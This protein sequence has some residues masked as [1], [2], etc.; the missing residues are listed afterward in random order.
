MKQCCGTHSDVRLHI[1]ISGNTA[2][3]INLYYYTAHKVARIVARAGS[4]T[5]IQSV[6]ANNSRLLFAMQFAD[7][8][9]QLIHIVLI[10]ILIL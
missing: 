2:Q 3:R 7:Y 4:K 8:Q 9:I 10:H 1:Y 6:A 5:S